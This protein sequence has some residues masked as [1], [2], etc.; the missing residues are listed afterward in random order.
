MRTDDE[1]AELRGTDAPLDPARLTRCDWPHFVGRRDI[2]YRQL[3]RALRVLHA[4]RLDADLSQR[5]LQAWRR[6]VEALVA[7]AAILFSAHDQV[8]TDRLAWP[9]LL[10]PAGHPEPGA[11]QRLRQELALC[12]HL[13]PVQPD[14]HTAD[15]IGTRTAPEERALH[16]LTLTATA[17]FS[18]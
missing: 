1:I 16:G 9:Y 8:I 13:D 11:R 15:P 12:R 10:L 17:D 14:R 4:L 6:H 18:P 3:C 2:G 5:T 7:Q